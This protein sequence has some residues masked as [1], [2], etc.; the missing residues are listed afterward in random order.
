MNH[1]MKTVLAVLTLSLAGAQAQTAPQTTNVSLPSTVPASVTRAQADAIRAFLAAGGQ[2]QLLNSA[3]AVI[4]TLNPDGTVA[5]VAGATLA[6]A[7]TVRVQPAAGQGQ[8]TTYTLARDL[9]KPGAIKFQVPGPNGRMLSLPLSAIVNRQAP[10]PQAKPEQPTPPEKGDKAQ[11]PDK[12]EKPEK[13][14]N[15]GKGKGKNK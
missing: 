10:T 14:E 7:R 6:D 11:K 5:L 1:S 13:P 4:G 8:A 12:P 2:V 15:P 9:G 3:G